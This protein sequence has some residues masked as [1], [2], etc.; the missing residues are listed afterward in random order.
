M[1]VEAMREKSHALPA[2]C[3]G[4]PAIAYERKE[5]STC[6]GCIHVGKA[7]GRMYCTKGMKT[8]PARC[9]NHY[10]QGERS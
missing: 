10:R 6:K 8:Y 5:A 9:K 3:Y 2:V 1:Q 4:D 7:L